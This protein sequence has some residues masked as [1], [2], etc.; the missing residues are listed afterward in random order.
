MNLEISGKILARNTLL[1]LI[2]QIIP[3]LVGIITIPFIIRG[4]GVERFGLLSLAW[5]VVGYFAIF[6]LGLG[7]GITKFVAEALGKGEDEQIPHLVWTA[8]TVQAIL[9]IAGALVLLGIT[10][11]LA[12][13]ILNIPTEIIS[14]AK[15]IF[16]ILSLSIPVI[17]VSSTFSG[18]LEAFQRF[19]LVNIVKV[20]SNTLTFLLPV[21]GLLLGF[22]LPGIV[23]LILF[24][25]IGTLVAFVVI[26]LCITPQLRRYSGSFSL[27]PRLFSFGG[28]V[29][30]SNIVGP[31]LVYLDRF[32]IGSLLSL[33]AV[34]YY[35]TPYEAV[36]RLW[37][38]SASLATTLFP[39]FSSL[40]GVKD[41]QKLGMLFARSVKYILLVSGPI[42]LVVMLFAK[43]ALQVWLGVDFAQQSTLAMQILALGVLI[44][45]LAHIPFALLQGVGRPDLPAKFHLLQL[46]IY[47]VIAW[48]SITQ[49][50]I[51]GAA[52]AWTFRIVLDT[53]LLF[54]ASF[55]VYQLTPR[56]LA[57]NGL[58]L[59]SLTFL[60]LVGISYGLKNLISAFPLFIQFT[61][62]LILIGLFVWYL[63]GKVLDVWDKNIILKVIKPW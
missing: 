44:N 26:N 39:A 43:E 62:F 58:T 36:T 6:D 59:A 27:F 48:F 33:A 16:Y 11:L 53:I 61:L 12:E 4:L 9:G 41:R 15:I 28:W 14:E 17:L 13:R 37:I 30:I 29:T 7:R 34:A 40:E 24:T 2:G 55:K 10:P 35:S 57:S 46:P 50:G 51:A 63:W 23:A 18:V 32:L 60:L 52:G 8:V 56:F 1:N 54:G 49:W 45:S 19:D 20:P 25:R 31:I 42:I 38:I 21:V 47:V 3:L 22:N 5:V